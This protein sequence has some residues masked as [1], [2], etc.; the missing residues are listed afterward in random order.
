MPEDHDNNYFPS[1][2]LILVY[3]NEHSI[4]HEINKNEKENKIGI[5]DVSI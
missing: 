4:N 3:W 5:E 2:K 1:T